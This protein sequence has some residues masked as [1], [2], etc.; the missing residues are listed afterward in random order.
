MFYIHHFSI[1]DYDNASNKNNITISEVHHSLQDTKRTLSQV[2]QSFDH[3]NKNLSEYSTAIL[4]NKIKLSEMR[5]LLSQVQI[6]IEKNITTTHSEFANIFS[7]NLLG[8]ISIIF[9][10]IIGLVLLFLICQIRQI[11]NYLIQRNASKTETHLM[12]PI[13]PVEIVGKKK[14]EKEIEETTFKF[15]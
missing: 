11:K 6:L 1:F 4:E 15:L 2:Q 7:N 13:Q 5:Q 8:I 14:D 3:Q 9:C 12:T 10:L